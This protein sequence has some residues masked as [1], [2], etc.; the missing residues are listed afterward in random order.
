MQ[1]TITKG[2]YLGFVLVVAAIARVLKKPGEDGIPFIENIAEELSG[3]K[4]QTAAKGGDAMEAL[5]FVVHFA[6]GSSPT[7]DGTWDEVHVA[8]E[9]GQQSEYL[10]LPE[11]ANDLDW[12]TVEDMLDLP[13]RFAALTGTV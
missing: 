4:S 3:C 5:D 6:M 11:C 8:E 1:D 13:R 12:A 10:A 2:V 9:E 7:G